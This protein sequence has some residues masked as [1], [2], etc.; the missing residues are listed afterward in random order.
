[1]KI[2]V[3]HPGLQPTAFALAVLAAFGPVQAQTT[4]AKP[5]EAD[6]GL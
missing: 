6:I 1:M 3:R 2:S 5:A 4:E